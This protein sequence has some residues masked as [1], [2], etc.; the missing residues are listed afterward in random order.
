[1]DISL[2]P[3]MSE[4]LEIALTAVTGIA[5]FVAGQIFMKWFIEGGGKATLSAT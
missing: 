3:G 1:M 4:G 5:V 2:Q